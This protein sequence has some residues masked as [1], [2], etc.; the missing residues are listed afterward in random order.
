MPSIA[1]VTALS[2]PIIS[3][4]A[5]LFGEVKG[6][7]DILYPDAIWR[8][9]HP[10]SILT[11]DDGPDPDK[12]PAI[13]DSLY[14]HNQQA[15]FFVVGEKAKR[16][17]HIIQRIHNEGHLLG[18][19][20]W[21]HAWLPRLSRSKLENEIA[22]CQTEIQ[23]ITGELPKYARPPYG[24]KDFRYYQLLRKYQLTPILWS[25]NI[26]DYY[27]SEPHKLVC[28][29]QKTKPGE[30]ILCH[31]GDRLALHTPQA[32]ENWLQQRPNLGIFL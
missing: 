27:G 11:F 21:S 4:S 29:L 2:L 25:R 19:H 16:Y 24:Q 13:L 22:Y 6:I 30:I 7:H 9:T 12:T 17:P 5:S 23:N 28:R 3:Y 26:H 31:D 32:I 8:T 1:I 15:I 10:Y 14:R 20:S 18:N